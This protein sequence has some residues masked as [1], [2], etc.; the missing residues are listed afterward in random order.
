MPVLTQ[1][2]ANAQLCCIQ[3]HPENLFCTEPRIPFYLRLVSWR[4]RELHRLLVVA[5]WNCLS[6][7]A[8]PGGKKHLEGC[9]L[10]LHHE[11]QP[12]QTQPSYLCR[13]SLSVC[14]W[15]TTTC[16]TTSFASDNCR[17]TG[18]SPFLPS[19]H[20]L[21]TFLLSLSQG[22]PPY[23]LPPQQRP[24]LP[25]SCLSRKASWWLFMYA[26][27]QVALHHNGLCHKDLTGH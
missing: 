2:L 20:D 27:G 18:Q 21:S 19:L 16:C 7:P 23:S 6:V 4:W 3:A 15:L 25:S 13:K 24:E 8:A 1:L 11:E 26:G 12:W 9:Q 22:L 5:M 10:W 14:C 17:S